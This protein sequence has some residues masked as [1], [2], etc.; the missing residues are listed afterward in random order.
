M[1]KKI[2]L[3][4]SSVLLLSSIAWGADNDG[5]TEAPATGA[6]ENGT[7][8][9]WCNQWENTKNDWEKISLT[10]GE[11]ETELNFAWY[12]NSASQTPEFR[13]YEDDELS[14]AGAVAVTQTDAVP[15][16]MSNKA[17]VKNIKPGVTYYYS[18]TKDGKWTAPAE[19]RSAV[20]A[21][22]FSF[23]FFGDPQIGSSLENVAENAGSGELTELG[24]DRAVRNDSFNWNNTLEKAME[25]NPDTAFMVSAGDQIQT[26]DKKNAD[27]SHS[28]FAENE[29]EYSGYLSPEILKSV[30]V[31]TTIG[32]HD[33]LSSNYSYHFNNP[34]ASDIGATYAG[35][36]YYFRYGNALFIMINTNNT[37][38]AEHASFVKKAC[39][40]YENA[41]WKI[42]TLHQDIYG[43]GE[44][45]NEPEIMELRYGL[46]PVFEE[47]GIDVVLTGHD[48]TY[49]R[50]YMMKTSV[51]KEDKFI[52]QDD[53]DAYIDG[54]K[55]IDSVYNDYLTSIEDAE[56]IAE[57][58]MEKAV[59]PEGILYLTANSASGSKYYDLVE[60][61][62]AYIASRWQE[63]VPT[64][65]MI[66]V[67][68]NEFTINTYRTDTMEKI[69]NEFTIVKDETIKDDTDKEGFDAE[70]LGLTPGSTEKDINLAWYSN[71][72][73]GEKSL[74]R[75]KTGNKV[76]NAEGTVKEVKGT[77]ADGD[78]V[79]AGIML[80]GK[81]S[82]K[83]SVEGLEA[84][85]E[86][87][88]Q[89]SNDGINWSK[90]Y[91][92]STPEEGDFKFAFVADPQIKE[93]Q[94]DQSNPDITLEESWKNTVNNIEE[95]GADF[96]ASAGDQIEG[97]KINDA[98][99]TNEKEY[100]SFF[101]PE[102]L[103]SIP[104]A[105]VVGNHDINY[106]F[107]YHF[108]LPNEQPYAM[109]EN[110][111]NVKDEEV[112]TSESAGN[113]YYSYND[114]L[115]VVLNDSAYPCDS[116]ENYEAGLPAAKQYIDEFDKTLENAVKDNP[117]YKWLFVQHHKSTRTAAQHTC[118]FDVQ[119]FVESGF[120]K[121]MDKYDVDFV[122]AG[123]DHVYTKSYVLKDGVITSE[124]AKNLTNPDGTVYFTGNTASGKEYY[125][126]FSAKA[127]NN[128]NYPIL[129][130]GLK[131]SEAFKNGNLPL[132]IAEAIQNKKAAYYMVDVTD[133]KVEIKAY[134][135]DSDIAY[136]SL[137]VI[138]ND[139]IITEATTVEDDT[140]TTTLTADITTEVT[141]IENN[142]ETSTL[143]ADTATETTTKRTTSG[144]GGGGHGASTLFVG[145]KTTTTTEAA[146]T[147][148]VEKTTEFTT[149]APLDVKVV[150]G[151]K[152]V[153]INGNEE[154]MDA[155]PYIQSSSNSTM[156]PLRFVALAVS[157]GDIKNPD[158][159]DNIKWDG[160]T[161]T[162]TVI[163]DK[164]TAS[165][166]A[167]S[168]IMTLNGNEVIMDNSVAAEIKDSRMYIPFRALGRVL[169][170]DVEWNAD[171]KTAVYK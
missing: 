101:A 76:I 94:S 157:T 74:V 70:D 68:N 130:N 26:R 34:N 25:L 58:D 99:K 144:N 91:N 41:P 96:I 89:V 139:D 106:G 33:A 59:N 15:G 80:T 60:H 16:Y 120:E 61:Q 78:A 73:S 164:S 160:V 141:T 54:D 18:Y 149:A 138:K 104:Y 105:A 110:F 21:S 140:E 148:A 10:P 19:Y 32:N 169:G 111:K 161:K 86:Y 100:S 7:W 8:E 114:V 165:F 22:D 66:D 3:L 56:Y 5:W 28:T 121:L 92:Y 46:S 84:G 108:N 88:Y 115:F 42:V 147:T 146:T 81:L 129:V 159:A 48:H 95:K 168:N 67:S 118:D 72:S 151:S 17:T 158:S 93:G 152:K 87:T 90:E 50:S 43:S 64:F 30:P 124:D 77:Y 24:Q 136:D 20:S 112:K 55:E 119:A 154:E 37:N 44:H 38:V 127:K 122:F 47:N 125:D 31:A 53:F 109:I 97:K 150:V 116:P 131:G 135:N 171:T 39:A 79:S 98:Y 40:S 132:G 117:D 155:V 6:A 82:H 1:R 52:S 166:K 162:V 45:S 143:T 12:S 83:V 13:W 65:S 63:D 137:V 156:V 51:K 102:E 107:Q 69:D 36:D 163:A 85:T 75:F 49:S 57:K 167:G 133:N 142:T 123:H 27:T 11:D 170:A 134:S 126:V 145:K 29:I 9:E 35:G 71:Q 103:K 128:E 14:P 153:S 4:L 113:Y 2:S 62:Q 23:V